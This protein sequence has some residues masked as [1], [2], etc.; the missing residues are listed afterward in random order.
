MCCSIDFPSALS[1]SDKHQ[2]QITRLLICCFPVKSMCALHVDT[3]GASTQFYSACLCN[4]AKSHSNQVV[5]HIEIKQM[6]NWK[7]YPRGCNTDVMMQIVIT[8]ISQVLIS[9]HCILS[10]ECGPDEPLRCFLHLVETPLPIHRLHLYLLQL[11]SL[12]ARRNYLC[13]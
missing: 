10:P 4:A 1:Y 3:S 7:V 8:L 5:L 2:L 12:I 6:N 11:Y 9:W 13:L